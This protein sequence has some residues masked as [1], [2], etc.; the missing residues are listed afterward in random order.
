MPKARRLMQR[1]DKLWTE[2]SSWSVDWRRDTGDQLV[3]KV[4]SPISP[5]TRKKRV[6]HAR[7]SKYL[8]VKLPGS[9]SL[10]RR[11]DNVRL[12]RNEWTKERTRYREGARVGSRDALIAARLFG[13]YCCVSDI[14]SRTCSCE[15]FYFILLGIASY[16]YL[17]YIKCGI[18]STNSML[19]AWKLHIKLSS[20]SRR[21]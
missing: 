1:T 5:R 10:T 12:E 19:Q 20:V 2:C 21:L 15:I 11:R 18:D 9:Q 17:L 16:K 4:G 13:L 6:N 3:P 7:E 8:L 14:C